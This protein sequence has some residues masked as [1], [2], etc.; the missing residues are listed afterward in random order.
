MNI[1][2][3]LTAAFGLVIVLMA[4]LGF[5]T[6]TK[7]DTIQDT[8]RELGNDVV[9]STSI[10]GN[11]KDQSGTY[12]RNQLRY[13]LAPTASDRKDVQADIDE[14]QGK[15]AGYTT[16]Y[17]TS[18]VSSTADRDA[19]NAFIAARAAYVKEAAQAMALAD[20]GRPAKAYDLLNAG[21]ISDDWDAV[22][23]TL[24]KWETVV[25]K[26]T[27]ASVADAEHQ[28][29]AT[30]RTVAIVLI[31][32]ILAAIA[33]AY[34]LTRYLT[35]G[36]RRLVTAAR[37]IAEGD[38]D[39]HIDLRSKDELGQAG[40][41][42]EGMVTYL[43]ETTDVAD[44]IAHGDLTRDVAPRSERDKLGI[45]LAEMTHSLRDALQ[46]VSSSAAAVSAASQEIAAS[47]SEVGRATHEV[48]DAIGQIAEGT[49][50]QVYSVG[51]ARQTAIDMAANIEQTSRSGEELAGAVGSA[52]EA[53]RAGIGAADRV[54]N[55][56]ESVRTASQEVSVAVTELG[57]KS[58]QIG[59]IVDTITGI[60]EQTNLLA[61]NA[62]IEAARAGEQGR[63]F[64][65]VA[66]EVRKL[67]E[68]SQTAAAS[69]SALIGEIQTE[70][71]RAVE[72]V[73]AGS[74]RS[75][76]GVATVAETRQ[77][78]AEI[79]ASVDDVSERVRQI[80]DAAQ[81]LAG[82]AQTLQ[83]NV[84]EVA[85]LAESASAST[86]EVSASTEETSAST[87]QVAA[88]AQ[89]LARTAEELAIL[90][91]RFQLEAAAV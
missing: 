28:V 16:Q 64:A 75:D 80:A 27:D 44:R 60:A 3:K 67:A 7:V 30:K 88:S 22:K 46:G 5:A 9:P 54:T 61:L 15:L 8:T 83:R 70:T 87:Q 66:E 35:G 40:A 25:T 62:A 71:K 2:T 56:M 14:A 89:D 32:A 33:M 23:D 82:G 81:A 1:R 55:A 74:R 11:L 68:E 52:G 48:A 86:E 73:E 79:G 19:M 84:D 53:A 18:M 51:E 72:V 69:I 49:E 39:Q 26:G 17:R 4:V 29:S 59:G 90:T 91:S 24:A 37:G 41:A 85:S 10:I 38:V 21:Q 65:V 6:W 45:A 42:F 34:V 43:Q 36:L 58:D 12:R 63:G 13:I 20:A 57:Q 76:E 78:F 31:A 77:A 50:R 47:S